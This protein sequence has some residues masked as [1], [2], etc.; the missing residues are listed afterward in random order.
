MAV[1]PSYSDLGK[2]AR[3]VFNKGYGFG[4][5][6]L[7]LKT[8]SSSGVEFTATGSSN[9]DTGKALG[10]LET[11]YKIKDYGLTFIQKWNTDN[12]L[13]TEVSMEDQ[14][15][16]TLRDMKKSGKLK[17]SYKRE[18]VNLGC[19]IDIDLSGPTI[20]GWAVLGYEGWLAGYQMAFDTSKWF[21]FTQLQVSIN[22]FTY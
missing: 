15:R 20:Y 5:V 3:D 2:S 22:H 1:P 19:N 14:V 10:N 18:Y 8:K 17:T 4:M 13:G 9:T 21:H 12:T 11:K 6:K 16:G 7:E